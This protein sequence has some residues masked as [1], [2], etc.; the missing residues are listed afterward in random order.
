MFSNERGCNLLDGGTAFY[1][2]YKT[3]DGKYMS[4]GA[5]EHKFYQDLLKGMPRF[6]FLKL[7]TS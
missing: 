5:L 6:M 7:T 2:T 4:V 1:S 3:K